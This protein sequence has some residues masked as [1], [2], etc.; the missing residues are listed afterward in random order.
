MAT[1]VVI[2]T[3]DTKLS[4]LLFLRDQILE[5]G[6]VK[7]ILI[8][9]GRY[10]VNDDAINIPQTE[11]LSKY[12][13]GVEIEN[14]TR[15]QYIEHISNCASE[16]VKDLYQ[17]GDLHGIV[18]AGGSGNTSLVAAVMRKV[19]PVG[20]PKLIVSTMASGDTGPTVGETDI[21]L[22]YSVVDIAGL[23][24]IL[25]QILGNAGASIAAA[26]LSYAKRRT[27]NENTR[28]GS[29]KKRVGI[30]MFG[31]TTPGV[32][33]IRSHLETNY[34]I[35]T[36]VFHATGSGGRAMEQFVR[37]GEL[38]AVLDL[39][40]TEICDHLMGGTLSAGES[41]LDAAVEAGLP[42]VV[43]LGAL[44]MANF[45][46][47]ATVPEKY[48]D[49]NLFVHNPT[50]TLLRSSPD[51]CKQIAEFICNKLRKTKNPD[52]IEVLFDTLKNGL[53]EIG[54]K[55]VEDE[56]DVNNKGFAHDIAE[57]L[58]R[59]PKI[60]SDALQRF[61]P[62]EAYF[63][64]ES[65][66]IKNDMWS[67]IQRKQIRRQVLEELEREKGPRNNSATKDPFSLEHGKQSQSPR[68]SKPPL[69]D[70]A[71]AEGHASPTDGTDDQI[72]VTC[73]T[74]DPIN[75]QDWPLISRCKNL[76]ILS[77]LIFV[78]GWAGASD[79]MEN[80]RASST[81]HVSKVTENLS[82]AVYLIGV[83][84][85]SPF[86]GPLSE[87]VGR[88]P[89]YLVSTFC[90]L[91][92]VLGSAKSRSFGGRIA[93]R[94]FV[95]LFSS[96]TLAIN[97][98]SVRDQFRSVKRAFVFPIIAWV[99]VIGPVLAPI[100]GGWLV[101]N[102]SLSWRWPDWVTLI[103]SGAAFLIA[104][105]F[106]PETYLPLLLD[107]KAKELRRA[108]GD[109]RY[110]SE[111]ARSTSFLGRLTHNVKLGASFFRTEV[112]I[113][114]LGMYLLLLY[115][116]LF[117]FLSG[118]DYIFKKTYQLSDGLTGT[119]FASIAAGSTAFTLGAP[120]FYIW[121][122]RRTEYV[123]GASLKPEFR[124]WPAV[125]T[126]PL[127]PICLF[128]LGW[129]NYPSIS[130]WSGLAACFVFGIVL[131]S[132]Y[133]SSYEYIIDSYGDHSA[134]A[135]ASIT[136]ARYLA[137]GGMV[138]A[139]RPMY[140]TLGVHWTM[141]LLGCVAAVLSP[142]PLLFKLYGSKLREKS[143]YAKNPQDDE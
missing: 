129:T 18:S 110:G 84:M 116:L 89:T 138:M 30:T 28:L 69:D 57:A 107:W 115:T 88:N 81:F 15:G 132:V 21:A 78:Q 24:H 103:I 66:P 90:Y 13:A 62:V 75:P 58:T 142:A 71:Q 70:E 125:V 106:L 8:D 109:M 143:K 108:T 34:P 19:L 61:T 96:S 46:P 38:D 93:C 6:N 136:M 102:P 140:E 59:A 100:A 32:D 44:D 41:R 139:A 126:A 31:V 74:D 63:C 134:I 2:G 124:L 26:A 87:S 118:F 92:F 112:I 111:H 98:S 27:S 16:A 101:S 55:V 76:A 127:L 95:G 114:V 52:L 51:D 83:G 82:T 60:V 50:I 35:E 94:Y 64:T 105:L 113:I 54:I 47:K 128:W 131:T 135:L 33:A 49:R 12:G 120:G 3:C 7:T 122:R 141:T 73:G 37:D 104:F 56:R 11:L 48:K 23:N 10:P 53:Q 42:N 72:I 29:S 22:M 77:F 123:R 9:V 133:V 91:C 4:E 36:Y 40:T 45:G 43:S 86:A 79:S 80:S 67:F 68:G 1:V 137:A 39:T 121:A 14:L 117:T 85:G 20:F 5:N 17:R 99:N 119:C 97:G 130:I 25:R 65:G